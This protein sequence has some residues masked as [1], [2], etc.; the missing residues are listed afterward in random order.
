MPFTVDYECEECGW[1]YESLFKNSHEV[2][3]EIIC[4]H[5]DGSM[6]KVFP[7]PGFFFLENNK[8]GESAKPA[9]YWRAAERER[10]S[11]VE[12]RKREMKEKEKYGDPEIVKR[13]EQ[14]IKNAEARKEILG[15]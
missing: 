15:E 1:K 12:K 4:P 14:Q 9:S 3:E 10:L 7:N 11:K 13:K 8:P 2:P 6:K 5:C